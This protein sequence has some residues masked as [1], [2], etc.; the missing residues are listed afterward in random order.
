MARTSASDV[1]D[2]FDTSIDT[3]VLS[4]Y[5]EAASEV[6]DDIADQAPSTDASRLEK[7]EKF[8]AAHLATAQDPRVSSRSGAAR[9]ESYRDVDGDGNASYK[10]VAITLDPTNTIA[11]AGL[12]NAGLSVPDA[13]STDDYP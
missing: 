6:V 11:G 4:A 10:Q 5:V 12:P 2:I 9:S 8:Y 3:T 13:K 7:I 1:A